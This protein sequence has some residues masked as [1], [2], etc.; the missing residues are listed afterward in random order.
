MGFSF[1]ADGFFVLVIGEGNRVV[2][3]GYGLERAKQV[4]G[5]LIATNRINASGQQGYPGGVSQVDLFCSPGIVRHHRI[6]PHQVIYA[7]C[8]YF[9][10]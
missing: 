3:I 10:I 8:I 5:E 7:M 9:L 1:W 2:E 6:S 4:V